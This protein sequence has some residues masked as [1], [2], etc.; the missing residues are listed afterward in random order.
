M[1][2]PLAIALLLLAFGCDRAVEI[3]PVGAERG[4]LTETHE[5]DYALSWVVALEGG[6]RVGVTKDVRPVAQTRCDIRLNALGYAENV[7]H[8]LR[9]LGPAAL[10]NETI[11]SQAAREARWGGTHRYLVV[12]F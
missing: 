11:V 9:A 7:K 4:A 5:G 2:H 8:E 3:A 10:P 1:R 12:T 6:S